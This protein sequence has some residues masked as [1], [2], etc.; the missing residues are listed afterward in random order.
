MG[1]KSTK[2]ALTSSHNRYPQQRYQQAIT[3][4][5]S[6]LAPR[7]LVSTRFTPRTMKP[8][9]RRAA[10]SVRAGGDPPSIYGSPGSRT[11]IVE[12]L[13]LEVGQDI[14][15]VN[16]NRAIMSSPEY[17]SV[18]PFGKIPGCKAA[19]G[20]GIFESGAIMLYIADLA[21]S[22][23]TP[24]ARGEA[25]AW[26]IWANATMWPAL[27]ASRGKCNLDNVFGPVDAILAEK[28]WLLGSELSVADVAVASYIK[29]GQLFFRMDIGAF[30]NVVRY[31]EQVEQREAFQ[32][33]VM[34]G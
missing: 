18:H 15:N 24:E 22:L 23:P 4:A 6:L 32:S 11:Q 16:L 12:W 29:Y 27:E 26:V 19:D 13:A 28:A 9:R 25:A 14:K 21:G 1:T 17:R 20:T 10:V 8:N 2:S 3:M 33:T 30:P 5:Q 31:M 34:G 7:A